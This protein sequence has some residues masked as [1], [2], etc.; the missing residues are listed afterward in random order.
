VELKTQLKT[1]ADEDH[2]ELGNFIEVELDHV[3]PPA[4]NPAGLS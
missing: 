4:E 1:L 3:G 2:R